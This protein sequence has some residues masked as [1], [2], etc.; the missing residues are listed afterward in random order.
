MPLIKKN[1]LRNFENLGLSLNV[2]EV[3]NKIGFKK[4]TPIQIQAIP[5]LLQND[6]TNFIGIAQTGTG[7]TAAFG[8]PLID[9]VD[10][11][12]K[13]TQAL[14][15]SPTRELGQQIAKMLRELSQNNKAM[16]VEVVYGGAAITNQIR[17]L[18]KTTQI[19]IA[20]PGRLL[21]LIGRKA[22]RLENVRYV[23][24][25][26]ADEMLN[27]GFKEDIDKI[28]SNIHGEKAIWLFS[29]TM[30]AG[31]RKIVRQYM[32]SPLE[33]TINREEK[34]N[35][36]IIHRYIVT[37]VSDK[38][39]ALRRF[40]DMQPEM[41]GIMFCR[42]RREAQAISE[43]LSTQGY[44]VE[45]LHGDLSQS[46]RDAVMRRFKLRSMQLLVATDVAAR[47]IDVSELTHVI[48]HKLP[49]QIDYYTHR[50]GRTG[51]VGKQ[52]ISLSFITKNEMRRIAELERKM[53]VKFEKIE[54]PGAEELKT[55]RLEEWARKIIEEDVDQNNAD[56]FEE[57]Q[58]KFSD[59]SKEELLKRLFSMQIRQMN[60]HDSD[61]RNL[62]E[63]YKEF[64]SERTNQRKNGR[65]NR[66]RT[67]QQRINGNSSG[68]EGYNRYF[69][70]IGA[71]DDVSKRDL[72]NFLAETSGIAHKFFGQ[73]SLQG[74]CT[75]FDVDS[76]K[77]KGLSNKFNGIEVDGR[78]IRVN[79]DIE[80]RSSARSSH[81]RKSGNKS[82]HRNSSIDKEV[83]YRK[84]GSYRKEGAYKKDR[85]HK[86]D[87]S[88]KKEGSYKKDNSRFKKKR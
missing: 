63:N 3:L 56:M 26:E 33:V 41:R 23:V 30:P 71:M 24:L 20:T 57:I 74:N 16:H 54:V 50:S 68:K 40:L 60:V 5:L 8:L 85:H 77:D 39:P 48:H 69:I 80:G 55:V 18:K 81:R 45:A 17:A 28:L 10:I 83:S 34:I 1:I 64:R 87:N 70:N 44:H 51:R 61:S 78:E 21:D 38:L 29:A 43:E 4:P 65:R 6:P 46:Q 47:G 2:I 14:I 19:V 66:E 72:I 75:Y 13:S 31:I 82:Y 27:M 42:T 67:E 53:D 37:R 86:K 73:M 9:L 88:F 62:N 76:S 35:K 25:D 36:D 22:I 79:R 49:D 11:N 32:Q 12:D 58:Q 15:L 7:K 52:G 84:N 59:L